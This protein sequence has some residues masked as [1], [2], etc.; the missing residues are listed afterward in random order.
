MNAQLATEIH[1]ELPNFYGSYNFTRWSILT[2]SVLT[3]GALYIAESA[4]AY[5][6]FDAIE[7]HVRR[8]KLDMTQSILHVQE[9]NTATLEIDDMDGNIVASQLI[10]Y[11]D[12]PLK[13]IKI[14]SSLSEHGYT[15]ML[16]S[17]Y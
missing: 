9:D 10:Q 17:E 8:L 14:W 15:H 6:L 12:F 4:Q 7:S 16:P 3:D 2:K 1:E 13:E 5:W 11:T